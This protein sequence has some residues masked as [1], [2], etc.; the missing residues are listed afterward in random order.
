MNASATLAKITERVAIIP[1]HSTVHVWSVI[2]VNVV[3]L[4]I[5]IQ[6]LVEIMEHVM[7]QELV[8]SAFAPLDLLDV[9]VQMM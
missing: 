2:P 8:I 4:I 1:E 5:V 6:I 7:G 9:C 3:R